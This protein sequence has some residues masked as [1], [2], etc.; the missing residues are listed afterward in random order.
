MKR[1]C[2]LHSSR[3]PARKPAHEEIQWSAD[4]AEKNQYENPTDLVLGLML[5]AVDEHRNPEHEEEQTA[6]RKQQSTEVDLC[7]GEGLNIHGV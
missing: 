7:K 3:S 1:R 6:Q 5:Y 4:D 2:R